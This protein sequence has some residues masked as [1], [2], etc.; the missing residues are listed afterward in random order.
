[1]AQKT[2]FERKTTAKN[3]LN[4]LETAKYCRFD[5][6]KKC[7]A[8]YDIYVRAIYF[9]FDLSRRVLSQPEA[10]GSCYSGIH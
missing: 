6:Y 3:D 5:Y 7:W 8:L 2:S 1:M 9:I 4:R 10:T